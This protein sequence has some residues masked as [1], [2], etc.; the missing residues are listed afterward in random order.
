MSFQ[1]CMGPSSFLIVEYVISECYRPQWAHTSTPQKYAEGN[2]SRV[3]LASIPKPGTPNSPKRAFKLQSLLY[4]CCSCLDNRGCG[5]CAPNLAQ[6]YPSLD[7]CTPCTYARSNDSKRVSFCVRC[8]GISGL[9]FGRSLS[10]RPFFGR[11]PS[12][13]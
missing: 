8:S 11:Q 3:A 5:R 6:P 12:S 2:E 4:T 9:F 10:Q 7:T 13:D 1:K